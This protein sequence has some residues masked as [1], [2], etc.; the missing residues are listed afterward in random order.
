M[1]TSHTTQSGTGFKIKLS[2]FCRRLDVKQ[3]DVRYVLHHGMVPDGVA[4][5]PG[6]GNHRTF[7]AEQAFWLAIVIKLKAAGLKPRQAADIADWSKRVKGFTRNLNWD[8]TFS[9]FDWALHTDQQW[10]IEVGDGSCVR[11]LTDANPSKIGLHDETG[12][13]SISSRKK[14]KGFIPV[15]TIQVNLSQLAGFLAE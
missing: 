12:W 5:D 13:V 11:I 7:N 4:E 9:P 1:A 10:L 6:Q 14:S 2:E 8:G 3:R 15:V